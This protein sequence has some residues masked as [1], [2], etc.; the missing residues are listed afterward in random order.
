MRT[1][2]ALGFLFLV[3]FAFAQ[4]DAQFA[5]ANQDYAQ[6][7]FKEAIADYEALV[8]SREWSANLFYN[9]GNA[10]FRTQDFG[11]AILNYE[12]A[13]ALDR[14]HPESDVNLRTALDEARALEMQPAWLDR[15]LQIA[16][17]TQYSVAAAIAFWVGAFSVV[18]GRFARRRAVKTTALSIFAFA[19][20][21]AAVLAIYKVENLE[22]GAAIILGK[23]VQARLATADSAGSVLALPSGSGIRILSTRGDWIYADLPNDL[24]GWIPAKDAELVR[25]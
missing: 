16:S 18:K 3:S 4:P 5:K 9:L 19:I 2:I 6:G 1:I 13:L 11:R 25:P 14:H 12:R 7:N 20:C 17:L 15:Y 24:R 8:Q 22:R 10:Y 23:D 21:V